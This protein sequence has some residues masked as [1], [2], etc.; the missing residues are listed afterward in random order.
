M[1]KALAHM[2]EIHGRH[3]QLLH[4]V[5]EI[6]ADQRRRVVQQTA[7]AAGQLDEK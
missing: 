1:C 7:Q 2:A 5:M 4:A 3:P 6:N